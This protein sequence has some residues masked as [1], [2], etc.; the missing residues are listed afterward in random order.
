[1]SGEQF[2]R[3]H[4]W[5]QGQG[6]WFHDR[7]PLAGHTMGV[8]ILQ[9]AQWLA[10][11]VEDIRQAVDTYGDDVPEKAIHRIKLALKGWP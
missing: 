3:A 4:G 8:A 9:Q 10:L 1:M 6:L 5:K 11:Q 7:L 2:L